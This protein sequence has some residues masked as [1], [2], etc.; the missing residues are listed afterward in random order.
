ML[1]EVGGRF[2]PKSVKR[3][4]ETKHRKQTLIALDAVGGG[5]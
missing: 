1:S 4:G 3:Y 5:T 2:A